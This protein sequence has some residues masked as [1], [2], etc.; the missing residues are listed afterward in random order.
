M[1][2]LCS[3]LVALGFFKEIQ[4]SFLIVGHTHIDIDQRFGTISSALKRQDIIS[5][6]ELLSIIKDKPIQTEPFVVAEHL[7]HIQ[8]W[9]SFITLYLQQDGFIDTSEPHDFRFYM[10]NT[11]P[12]VQYKMY[13]RSPMWEPNQDYECLDV[14]PSIRL[15]IQF[16]VVTDP[17]PQDIKVLEDYITLK[18][19]YIARYQDVDRNIEAVFEMEWLISYLKE[20]PTR[21]RM[22]ALFWPIEDV[23]ER[24]V[25]NEDVPSSSAQ[26]ESILAQLS[27]VMVR[28]YFG[29]RSMRPRGQ[30]IR[31]HTMSPSIRNNTFTSALQRPRNMTLDGYGSIPR[32]DTSRIQTS[33]ILTVQ[34]RDPFPTFDP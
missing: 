12:Q 25:R 7:E 14:V 9:K 13:T 29:P 24:Q 30:R 18:E 21:D 3:T 2:A 19:R 4:L 31:Q 16:A 33:A 1:L 28:E 5:L 32:R 15:P 27:P 11:I 8:D 26:Y 20:F 34:S 23:E 17:E 22:E 6:K 10:D